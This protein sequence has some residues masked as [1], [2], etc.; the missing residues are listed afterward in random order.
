MKKLP[1]FTI[2]LFV[3]L[4]LGI[5]LFV[6]TYNEEQAPITDQSS[7]KITQSTSENKS[8]PEIIANETEGL[9]SQEL[10]E[11]QLLYLIE[12]E[13]LAHDVYTIFYE[14]Y[15]ARVFGNILESESTHQERVLTL[16]NARNIQDPRSS[17][18]GVFTNSDLQNF[19]NDLIAQGMQSETEAFKA[20]VII[21]E[22]D[23]A[24]LTEQLSTTTDEDVVLALED[25]RRG[26][27]N[28]LRAFNKQL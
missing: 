9:A 25:L 22:T 21:E 28:H 5:I 20:G 12:E 23:I 16:L 7:Q 10:T 18:I 3:V 1:I 13:K 17:E 15:G 24:D 27:E 4:V 11:Q 6:D 26:S 8:Q 14:K 2:S 19:Y